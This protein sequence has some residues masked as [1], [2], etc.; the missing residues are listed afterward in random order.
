[1]NVI[2]S[3]IFKHKIFE[4]RIIYLNG[5]ALRLNLFTKGFSRGLCFS[6]LSFIIIMN[7]CSSKILYFVK[8]F[9]LPS[10]YTQNLHNLLL[11]IVHLHT[12]YMRLFKRILRSGSSIKF[13]EIFPSWMIF[14]EIQYLP[15]WKKSLLKNSLS[16]I[17]IDDTLK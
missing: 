13:N 2:D 1:M 4:K 12:T 16:S 17:F 7:V 6:L 5:N 14:K 8:Y 9:A 3:C 11:K 10:V 15:H